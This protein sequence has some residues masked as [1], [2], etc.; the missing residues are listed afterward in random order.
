MTALSIVL[1]ICTLIMVVAYIIKDFFP[2]E[3]KKHY[4][5][6]ETFSESLLPNPETIQILN[7]YRKNEG[8]RLLESK[9]IDNTVY[10]LDNYRI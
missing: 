2:K 6:S 5:T 9:I 10:I 4:D 1:S 8:K 3:K 7:Q